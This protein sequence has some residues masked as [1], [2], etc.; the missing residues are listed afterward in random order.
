MP[1]NGTV[2]SYFPS[3]KDSNSPKAN[4]L[5]L[6]LPHAPDRE[7]S[8][9]SILACPRCFPQRSR[10]NDLKATKIKLTSR[11]F[12][13]DLILFFFSLYKEFCTL[14]KSKQY[15]ETL[16]DDER[17][18]G[19]SN[20]SMTDSDKAGETANQTRNNT[21]FLFIFFIYFIIFLH[22]ILNIF[23]IY[24]CQLNLSE[25]VPAKS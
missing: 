15:G 18:S 6:L 10:V 22:S 23:H 17:S 24:L 19:T 21:G 8:N 20:T 2:G 25:F 13:L 12:L 7:S 9:S 3:T 14:E 16:Q 4:Y 5:P 1:K 11:I